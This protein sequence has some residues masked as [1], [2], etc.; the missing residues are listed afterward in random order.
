MALSL[1]DASSRL[2]AEQERLVD[3]FADL[4]AVAI[5]R[6]TFAGEARDMKISQAATEKLQTALLDSISHDL[7]TP[8]A[9]V[10]GVLSS[11]QEE[12]S[13]LDDAAKKDLIQVAF[14]EAEEL[15]DSITNL[16]DMSRIQAGAITIS[17]ESCDLNDIISVALDQLGDRSKDR[18]IRVPE[19]TELPFV[20]ADFGLV[21][22]VLF[23]LLDN[24]IRY[25]SPDSPVEINARRIAQ[26][27]EIEVA[28]RGIGIP[29]QH[30]PHIFER[31]HRM[32]HTS[33][34]GTGLGLS[35]CKGIVEA[36]GGRIAVENRHGGGTIIRVTLPVAE[37]ISANEGERDER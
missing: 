28:D 24:A 36:H 4:G 2:T 34:S 9:S 37:A 13:G 11:L 16:L 26:E 8:L 35:I 12:G 17:T 6:I 1:H 27:V 19:A 22:K 18:T 25:S 10:I 15:N 23:N 21:V 31:F 30:L 20:S 7:R 33:V 14:K 29:P 32:P 5:E 3:A